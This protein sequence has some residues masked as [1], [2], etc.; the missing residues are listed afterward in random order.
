MSFSM[1]LRCGGAPAIGSL[2]FF[3]FAYNRN[4]RGCVLLAVPFPFFLRAALLG[5]G[6]NRFCLTWAT[7]GWLRLK[8]KCFLLSQA[9][10]RIWCCGVVGAREIAQ[11]GGMWRLKLHGFTRGYS[12]CGATCREVSSRLPLGSTSFGHDS[13]QNCIRFA[14]KLDFSG[15]IQL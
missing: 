14:S 10:L 5:W 9:V 15:E 4:A 6:A 2:F 12:Y 11:L 1:L 13:L 8:G 7:C 3:L